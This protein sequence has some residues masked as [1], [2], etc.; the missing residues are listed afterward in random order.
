[1]DKF[2]LAAFS[3]IAFKTAFPYVWAEKYRSEE[4]S[5]SHRVIPL[6]GNE[7]FPEPFRLVQEGVSEYPSAGTVALLPSRYIV[8]VSSGFSALSVPSQR[9]IIL[10]ESGHMFHKDQRRST[11]MDLIIFGW[12]IFLLGDFVGHIIQERAG[13]FSPYN[14]GVFIWFNDLC[15]PILL[16]FIVFY[17][18]KKKHL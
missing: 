13:N 6:P 12:S 9:F 18:R 1:M 5:A 7:P 4:S 14:S 3:F 11:I 10:H 15:L 2:D 8:V 17:L 16:L